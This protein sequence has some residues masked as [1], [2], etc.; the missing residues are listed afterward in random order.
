MKNIFKLIGIIA[1]VAVF[2][3]SLASCGPTDGTL[4]IENKTGESIMAIWT[5]KATLSD[6]EWDAES[7]KIKNIPNGNSGTWDVPGDETIYWIWILSSGDKIDWG[8]SGRATIA[9]GEE[10]KITA[11]MDKARE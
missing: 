4:V 10:V 9:A 5:S 7:A 2:G 8:D 6:E 11:T 3:L 1:I